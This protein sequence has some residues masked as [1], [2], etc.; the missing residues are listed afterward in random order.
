MLIS[1][2]PRLA[3][4]ATCNTT[5]STIFVTSGQNPSGIYRSCIFGHSFCQRQGYLNGYLRN[6]IFSS[7]SG[8]AAD[9]D[10]DVLYVADTGNNA[11]RT[12]HLTSGI[13]ETL[14][15]GT[16]SL[17]MNK[18]HV[19]GSMNIA[20]FLAPTGL[21]YDRPNSVLYVADSLNG[22][23][24]AIDIQ[25]RTVSTLAGCK[26]R[27]ECP[28]SSIYIGCWCSSRDGV[29][30]AV[31]LGYSM[32]DTGA[33]DGVCGRL[34]MEQIKDLLRRHGLQVLHR[35]LPANRQC[36]DVGGAQVVAVVDVPVALARYPGVVTMTVLDDQAGQ[37]V[38][39]RASH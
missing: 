12:V 6:A 16:P 29:G 10:R 9:P 17:L 26:L 22:A 4:L 15:G 2:P 36:N 38:P 30:L 27:S 1:E 11:V 18:T 39:P 7:P 28:G 8:M 24:R 31:K 3:G 33:Q 35:P 23:V 19:D 5:L 25:G 32:V 21:A 14:S 37:E 20:Q 13:V 34:A